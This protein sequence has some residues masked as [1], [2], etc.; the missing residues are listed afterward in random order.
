VPDYTKNFG[1][2]F[3]VGFAPRE[4]AHE[5]LQHPLMQIMYVPQLVFIDRKGLIKAQYAGGSDFFKD[6]ETNIRKQ[7]DQM[8]KEQPAPAG[9]VNRKGAVSSAPRKAVTTTAKKAS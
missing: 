9:G 7:I 1:I 5:F 6:E 3:P 4:Q 2:R 8:L